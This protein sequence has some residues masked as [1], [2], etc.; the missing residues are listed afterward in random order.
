MERLAPAL[1]SYI[2]EQILPRYAADD[3]GHGPDHIAYVIRRSLL[4]AEQFAEADINMVFTVAAYHD[5]GCSIDRKNH[6]TLSAQMFF[7]DEAMKR[8]FTDAQ[9]LTIKEAIEDHRASAGKQPRSIYG[10]IVSSADRSSDV[11][12]FLCRAHSYTL[13]YM[14]G[15][16]RQAMIDRAR[17]HTAAKYGSGG[18]AKHYVKDAEYEQFLQTIQQ[19]L[20]DEEAFA[21]RYCLVND[22]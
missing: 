10:K 1:K 7:A 4:F 9:R 11:D 2:E 12:D 18:Y 3:S 15:C 21:A 19:L 6:E 22:L 20:Q 8:F 16:D 5:I 13:K 14:P 17:E